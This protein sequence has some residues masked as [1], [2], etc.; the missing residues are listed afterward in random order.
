MDSIWSK[1]KRPIFALAPMEDV[2]DTVFRRI[3]IGLGRPDLFFT[4][5]TSVEGMLSPG[6]KEV[7]QRL[8][9]NP[10]EHPLIAQIWGTDPQKFYLAA[11]EIESMDFDGIDLNMGCPVAK[12]VKQGACSALIKNPTLAR[13]IYLATI[14]G[15]GK[16]PVSIKTRIG[17][18]KVETEKWISFLLQLKPVA[19][20]VHGRTASWMSDLPCDWDEIKK[21]VD[22]KN[23]ISPS[24]VILGNGDVLNL[25]QG[26]D[27]IE[28]YGVDGCMIGRGIFKNPWLFNEAVQIKDISPIHKFDVLREHLELFENTWKGSKNYDI[29][30][31]YFKIYISNFDG[32]NELRI[33]FMETHS[34]AEA[35]TLWNSEKASMSMLTQTGK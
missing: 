1:L 32:A 20:T 2:T 4:E 3:I 11:K 23:T 26:L 6:A 24:T 33:K 31:K 17:F 10:I 34:V 13:E 25:E 19:L 30:K 28:K 5:F 18:E 29:L 21:A 8:R 9:F 14:E 35:L 15:A 12:I 27:Y 22:L 16:L 7:K